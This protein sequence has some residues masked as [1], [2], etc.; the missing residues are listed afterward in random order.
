MLLWLMAIG[1]LVGLG[2]LAI[3]NMLGD[4]DKR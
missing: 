4:D 1:F 2:C 3:S